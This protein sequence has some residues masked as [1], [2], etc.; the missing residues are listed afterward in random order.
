MGKMYGTINVLEMHARDVKGRE[1]HNRRQYEPGQI[2]ENIDPSRAHLN[3][4]QIIGGSDFNEAINA[5]LKGMTVRKNAV[6]GLEYILGA[7]PEFFKQ[8]NCKPYDYLIKC[9]AF[10]AKKHGQENIF[11]INMHFDEKT[12]HIHIIVTPIVEKEVRWKNKKRQGVSKERRL[13]ARD[14][15]GHPN[16]LRKLQK[17]FYEYI[18]PIG[19][20]VGVQ[21]T[22]Y[23]SIQEQVKVY[24]ERVD[25]QIDKM[26]K[27]AELAQQRVL[28]LTQQ[29][30]LQKRILREKEEL[31]KARKAKI[32]AEQRIKQIKKIN[33]GMNRDDDDGP[34]FSMGM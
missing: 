20:A 32:E 17:D 15:T 14:F 4:S 11:A 27:L 23:T 33:K 5:R 1:Q 34:S 22:K 24:S 31:D 18:V 9:A 13:C 10:I 29:L 3:K 12:P 26:N 30:E 8:A 2:P 16:M 21:F 25:H 19:Q 7:S 28:D 6:V